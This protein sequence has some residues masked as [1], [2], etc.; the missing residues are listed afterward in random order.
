[1]HG[2]KEVWDQVVLELAKSGALDAARSYFTESTDDEQPTQLDPNLT[3]LGSIQ[4]TETHYKELE[5]PRK[6]APKVLTMDE[7]AMNDGSAIYTETRP[8][9]PR[10]S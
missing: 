3:F 8:L 7:V 6:R 4:E 10:N 1:M 5:E 2:G 9:L